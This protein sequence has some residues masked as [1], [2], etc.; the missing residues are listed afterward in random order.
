LHITG[1]DIEE[2]AY[3]MHFDKQLCSW[4]IPDV[5]HEEIRQKPDSTPSKVMSAIREMGGNATAQELFEAFDWEVTLVYLRTCLY[6]LK[7]KGTLN[8]IGSKF[9]IMSDNGDNDVSSGSDDT[10]DNGGGIPEKVLSLSSE[11]IAMI[12][13]QTQS[14][15]GFADSSI[16]GITESYKT[17]DSSIPDFDIDIDEVQK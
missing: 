6:R 12:I 4:T 10:D 15:S 1:R 14:K 2:T 11:P 13:P 3:P 16:I 5:T 8:Q 9:Y 17:A 7:G